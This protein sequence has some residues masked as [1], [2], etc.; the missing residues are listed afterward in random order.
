LEH[1]TTGTPALQVRL[2]GGQGRAQVLGGRHGQDQVAGGQGGHVGEAV[3]AVL[4]LHAGQEHR[5]L[6]V[7]GDRGH[8]LGSRACR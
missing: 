4:Q 8:D 1:S 7:G 3:M 2:Q 5:V 6:A